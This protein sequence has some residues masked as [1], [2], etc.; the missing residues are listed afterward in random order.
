MLSVRTSRSNGSIVVVS[1]L[2]LKSIVRTGC[3]C[4][5]TGTP[6]D[7][8]RNAATRFSNVS[9]HEHAVARALHR[10]FALRTVVL[11]GFD[12]ERDER[13]LGLNVN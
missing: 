5:P 1:E 7:L 6:T 10:P 12:V 8:A 11:V 9:T 3:D 13:G 2:L 4:P